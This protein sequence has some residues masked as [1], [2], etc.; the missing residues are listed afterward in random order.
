MI[1]LEKFICCFLLAVSFC[2]AYILFINRDIILDKISGA[3]NNEISNTASY[4]PKQREKAPLF[5]M[6]TDE[7]NNPVS[8]E[9]FESMQKLHPYNYII[10]RQN[11]KLGLIDLNGRRILPSEY[12]RIIPSGRYIKAVNDNNEILIDKDGREIFSAKQIIKVQ[13]YYIIKHNLSDCTLYS[14][15]LKKLLS[16]KD[17][18]ITRII[19]KNGKQYLLT[20]INNNTKIIDFNGKEHKEI[21]KFY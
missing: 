9:T 13:N 4:Y 16:Y 14:D 10:V 8:N 11:K 6:L 7:N 19:T 1:K 21:L 3:D 12:N 15:D 20:R 5:Y 2:I 18:N 17:E